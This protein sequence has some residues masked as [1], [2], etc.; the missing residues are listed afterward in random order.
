M[1]TFILALALAVQAGAALAFQPLIGETAGF[2]GLDGRQIEGILDYSE[3]HSG[4]GRYATSATA[5]LSY[6]LWRDLDVLITVPWKGWSSRGL[7]RSGLGDV[8]VEAK[9]PLARRGGWT[10]GIKPGF[11]LPEGDEAN[12]LG[13]GKGGMWA[14][15]LA[16]RSAGA[17]RFCL[18]AG[19]LYNRNSIGNRKNIVKGSASAA[20]EILP[21]ALAALRV[22]GQ[23]SEDSTV[24]AVP[25]YAETGLVWSPY[26][27]LDLSAGGRLGLNS[28]SDDFGLT[29]AVTLRL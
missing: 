15:G 25:L 16:S 21:G 9:F 8:L 29:G 20:L 3:A 19:Y 22:F 27:T 6:G 26:R 2:L 13:A 23:T 10:L 28:G 12:S 4:P 24:A 14:L 5:E 7:S 18:N 17:W 11:S 1:K